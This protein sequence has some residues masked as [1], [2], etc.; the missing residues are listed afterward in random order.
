[1]IIQENFMIKYLIFL[2]VFVSCTKKTTQNSQINS[3]AYG[4]QN[5]QALEISEFASNVQLVKIDDA[6]DLSDKTHVNCGGT[7]IAKN[8]VLSIASCNHLNT[9]LIIRKNSTDEA[10][11]VIGPDGY[12]Y[13]PHE[14]F[15]L[16]TSK[17]KNNLGLY[18]IKDEFVSPESQVSP[19]LLTS[20]DGQNVITIG[21]GRGYDK[22]NDRS[23]DGTYKLS[24]LLKLNL[25]KKE[26]PSWFLTD[27][28]ADFFCLRA[29]GGGLN[30][31]DAGNGVYTDTGELMGILQA[32]DSSAPGV[33]RSKATIVVNDLS[34]SA[35]WIKKT[36]CS[37]E[38]TTSQTRSKLCQESAEGQSVETTIEKVD[39][40]H[41]VVLLNGHDETICMGALI[42]SHLV[43]TS[44]V[45]TF[46]YGN[47]HKVGIKKNIPTKGPRLIETSRIKNKYFLDR[48][49][50]SG[51]LISN[52]SK[53]YP[54][55]AYNN[56][57]I[58]ELNR[59]LQT[60]AS[61]I[62]FSLPKELGKN[63]K[64]YSITVPNHNE[65]SFNHV[66]GVTNEACNELI[67]NNDSFYPGIFGDYECKKGKYEACDQLPPGRG[68]SYCDKETPTSSTEL[69]TKKCEDNNSAPHQCAP[70]SPV[71]VKVNDDYRI[72][73][74]LNYSQRDLS[75][76]PDTYLEDNGS[77]QEGSARRYYPKQN[78]N[79]TRTP[80]WF[81][82]TSECLS[83]SVDVYTRLSDKK[84]KEWIE[85]VIE[86]TSKP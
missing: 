70:G 24:N 78:S 30:P 55:N 22:E 11:T 39:L 13:V 36:V 5:G 57:V 20:K 47:F 86:Q 10:V 66:C 54:N 1:M 19:L 32:D 27:E 43:L 62:E 8:I 83:D 26:C 18:F 6:N 35:N 59:S 82:K 67:C 42:K 68:N 37:H 52:T 23:V 15:R 3:Q 49:G 28:W 12:H 60:P 73:G 53:Y 75:E 41:Q 58:L 38:R 51:N 85:K 21:M 14:E 80:K 61:Q 69:C 84:I 50:S 9:H 56:L 46:A 25:M 74:I 76:K 81:P 48:T 71:Y 29:D 45:C 16:T 4:I 72:A 17:R 79:G 31:G 34:K 7:L 64:L 44:A 40:E 63:I 77:S 33:G 65:T 2:V